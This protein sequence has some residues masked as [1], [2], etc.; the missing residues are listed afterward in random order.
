MNVIYIVGSDAGVRVRGW[1]SNDEDHGE[2]SSAGQKMVMAQQLSGAV[3][4]PV[5]LFDMFSSLH[6]RCGTRDV[7]SHSARR[8]Y[9]GS[10]W[11]LSDEAFPVGAN[12][13][14]KTDAT[15]KILG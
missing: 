7:I 13:R 1:L 2:N 4:A 5:T 10:D 12:C 9:T 14:V 6:L 3:S 8:V 11:C 15:T